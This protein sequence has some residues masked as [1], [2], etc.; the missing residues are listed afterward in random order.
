M[1]VNYIEEEKKLE[2]EMIAYISKFHDKALE[3]LDK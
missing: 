2:A 3:V 1:G